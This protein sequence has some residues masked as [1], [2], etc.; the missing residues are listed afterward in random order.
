MV[1]YVANEFADHEELERVV[2]K[3]PVA[4]QLLA[5]V[6]VFQYYTG[7]VLMGDQNACPALNEPRGL[8]CRLRRARRRQVLEDQELVESRVGRG[9][10]R[11][12]RA[13]ATRVTRTARAAFERWGYYPVFRDATTIGDDQ[14]CEKPRFGKE[15]LGRDLKEVTTRNAE[16]CCEICRREPGCKAVTWHPRKPW[17]CRLKATIEGERRYHDYDGVSFVVVKNVD[18]EEEEKKKKE[19][20]KRQQNPIC[21]TP[22]KNVDYPGNDLS[23]LLTKTP[24]QCCDACSRNSQCG[25]YTWSQYNGGSCFLKTRKPDTPRQDKPLPNG[26]AY[27]VSG[28]TY[29]CGA[30]QRGSTSRARISAARRRCD[31]RSAAAS[32]ARREAVV[33][34]RGMAGTVARAG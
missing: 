12:P 18:K 8:D 32:A 26:S 31:R 19:E 24:E 1:S 13:E 7:G 30:L 27:F 6:P 16:H 5:G 11:I 21:L 25:A 9:G 22:E 34:S 29:R 28:E 33:R 23:N 14:H 15:I 20:E 2:A 17:T 10:L 3:Q 4:V